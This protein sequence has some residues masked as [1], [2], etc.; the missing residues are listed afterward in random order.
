F[1]DEGH[2]AMTVERM[3]VLH[4]VFGA[5]T[6]RIALTATPD[7]SALRVLSEHFPELIHEMTFREALML[8]LLAPVKYW[9]R[10]IEADASLVGVRG[11]DYDEETLGRILSELPFFQAA[12]EERFGSPERASKSALITC[13]SVQ[14]ALD[15]RMWLFDH[16]PKDATVG[17]II[18]DTSPTKRRELIELFEDGLVGTLICVRVLIEGWD[19]AR[20]KLLV[21]LSPTTSAVLGKQKYARPLTRCNS[22]EAHIVV[23]APKRL[24]V[25]P[26]LPTEMFGLST[27][28]LDYVPLEMRRKWDTTPV[29]EPEYV[30]LKDMQADEIVGELAVAFDIP[31]QLDPHSD[32]HIKSVIQHGIELAVMP[33]FQAFRR[34]FFRHSLFTGNGVQLLRYC[35]VK[36]T[37]RGYLRFMSRLFPHLGAERYL[38]GLP[39]VARRSCEEDVELAE[40]GLAAAYASGDPLRIRKA[41]LGWSALCGPLRYDEVKTPEA[42]LM[43]ADRSVYIR[44]M[45]TRLSPRSEHVVRRRCFEE[46]AWSAIGEDMGVSRVQARQRCT[47]ACRKAGLLMQFKRHPAVMDWW[48]EMTEWNQWKY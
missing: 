28:A 8:D 20:C 40:A 21:D 29:V 13:A 34:T 3:R 4:E 33:E 24:P 18:G 26:Y 39:H 15:L 35:G 7:Y 2:H 30:R 16:A 45:L 9:M 37:V 41:Q 32:R 38:R 17:V 10:L 1:V 43:D 36:T 47:K 14:Q 11:G 31:P 12:L 6:M 25:L 19:S 44:E 27:Y 22:D 23:I 5:A 46:W 48:R 42:R